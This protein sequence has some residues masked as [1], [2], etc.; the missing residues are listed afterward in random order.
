MSTVLQEAERWT[1]SAGRVLA[2]FDAPLGIPE[3]YLAA[4]SRVPEWR[5][6]RTFL[7]FLARAHSTPHFFD[8][9]FVARD[10][11]VKRIRQTNYIFPVGTSI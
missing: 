5:S 8:E 1:A 2:T 4:A 9:T 7:E 3:S 10:W 11:K 6:P